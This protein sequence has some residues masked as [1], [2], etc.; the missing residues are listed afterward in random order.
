MSNNK[1]KTFQRVKVTLVREK[2]PVEYNIIISSPE[3]TAKVVEGLHNSD[4][5]KVIFLHL[6]N[7]LKLLAVDEVSVGTDISSQVK[8]SMVF[9]SALETGAH[10]LIMVHNHPS[11]VMTPS[12]EDITMTKRI[13][14]AGDILGIEVL[15]HVIIGNDEQGNLDYVSFGELG[16]MGEIKSHIGEVEI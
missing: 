3:E 7:K 6:N 4:R 8:P 10:S 15:D 16:V 2:A 11:G 1:R 13:M 14:F 9:R 5:E 12:T